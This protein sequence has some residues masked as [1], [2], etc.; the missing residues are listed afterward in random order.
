[1]VK[2]FAL[3]TQAK[4][5]TIKFYCRIIAVVLFPSV[6]WRNGSC[7]CHP[8]PRL[9]YE[10]FHFI[11]FYHAFCSIVSLPS[12][13]KTCKKSVSLFWR[14]F[15]P[16]A[17]LSFMH[18]FAMC[19]PSFF[20]IVLPSDAPGAKNHEKAMQRIKQKQHVQKK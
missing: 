12:L 5:K 10:K 11:V 19:R 2:Y 6:Y 14:V 18:W 16:P 15:T 4:I 13:K 20:T 8:G 17:Y 3:N 9:T 1:M 7:L